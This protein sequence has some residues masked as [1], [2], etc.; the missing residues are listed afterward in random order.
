M[1]QTRADNKL[2]I[3]YGLNALDNDLRMHQ[4]SSLSGKSSKAALVI[5]TRTHDPSKANSPIKKS[6]SSSVMNPPS[7]SRSDPKSILV[8]SKGS[9]ASSKDIKKTLNTKSNSSLSSCPSPVTVVPNEKLQVNQSVPTFFS[10]NPEITDPSPASKISSILASIS[11]DKIQESSNASVP[12]IPPEPP[13]TTTTA[14]FNATSQENWDTQSM[15]PP[16][17]FRGKDD[18]N[19]DRALTNKNSLLGVIN[20]SLESDPDESDVDLFK[21]ISKKDVSVESELDDSIFSVE[22]D[23]DFKVH[24]VHHG[25]KSKFSAFFIISQRF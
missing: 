20:T 13:S 12:P 19:S 3:W 23:D 6:Q 10:N 4:A 25:K 16:K 2:T 5:P 18:T 1:I 22:E 7:S 21:K 17:Q 11:P 15:V 9:Q 14:G 8:S 24:F